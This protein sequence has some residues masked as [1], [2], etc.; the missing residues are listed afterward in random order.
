[1]TVSE[2]TARKLI[3]EKG[4]ADDISVV[5]EYLDQLRGNKDIKIIENIPTL[6]VVAVGFSWS[7]SPN[8]KYIGSGKWDGNGMPPDFF[9]DTNARKAV[10]CIINYDAVIR[11]VLKGYGVRI[12][13]A[14]PNSLLGFDPTLPLY[15]FNIAEARKALE[16][17]WDGK[18]LKIGLKFS[19]A[20]NTGNLMRQRIAEMIKTYMEMIAPGKIKVDVVALNWPSYLDAMRR[21]ELPMPIFNWIADFPDPD[22]FIFTFYHS[23]GTYAPR[24]GENFKKFVS[25][26]RKE[27]GGKSL[28]E[29]I[30]AARNSPILMNAKDFISRFKSSQS[31]II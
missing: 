15:K 24:Q 12:P 3:L 31:I 14:L 16:K 17:A 22:N 5:L 7:V 11:D 28:D 8:S 18:A 6:S 27:L 26:P 4:D 20:Y 29:L 19:I 21:S 30:E 13:S 23:A 2:W 1:M 9:S 10:A 25:T